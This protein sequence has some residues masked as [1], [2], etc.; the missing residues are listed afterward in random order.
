MQPAADRERAEARDLDARD[1]L[2]QFRER[3]HFPLQADGVPVTYLNGNSLGLAPRAAEAIV[4]RELDDWATLAVEAHFR[5]EAPWYTYH[6]LLRDPLAR[7]VGALPSEVVA[8]N[9]LSVNLHLLMVSFYRPTQARH[10]VLIE[11]HA[12][13]SDAYAVQSQLRFH[14]FDPENGIIEVKA[15]AGEHALRTEDIDRI[16]DERGGEIALVLLGG[17]NYFTGQAFDIAA[18]ARA[19]ARAGCVVGVDLAHAAGNILLRLHDWQVDF[20]VWCSYKYLNG[21]PGAPG[22]AFVHE[23]FGRDTE[24]ARFAGWW[25]TDPAER[26][27]MHDN[28]RFEPRAGAD[29]WQLSNPPILAMAPLRAS[30]ACFDEAGMEALRAKSVALTGFAERLVGKL[31]QHGVEIITPSEPAARGCQLSLRLARRPRA[32]FEAL[33]ARG[34][35]V[36]LRDPDVLRIAAVPLYNSFEDVRH[37]AHTLETVLRA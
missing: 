21:G 28:R 35:T 12:F 26:F 15:R 10:K 11:E 13:P 17:V 37:F 2:A 34:V 27:K 4:R 24:R 32:T 31:K 33:C 5:H 22:G 30:L 18:I 19:A 29:G 3:F 36:D 16:L 8:M 9:S 23:R 14:G 25:G 1:P 6:E 7:L 20:A